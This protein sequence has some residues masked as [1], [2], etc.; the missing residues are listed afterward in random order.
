VAGF[1]SE[2]EIVNKTKKRSDFLPVS[3]ALVNAVNMLI[4]S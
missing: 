2:K 3:Q 4:I 1:S